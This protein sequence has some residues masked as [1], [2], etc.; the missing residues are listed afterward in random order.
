[1]P[2]YKLTE[3]FPRKRAFVTGAGSGLGRQFCLELA[4]DGWT[5]G[6]S[7]L[8]K[9]TVEETSG[10]VEEQGGR[11]LRF[12][13]DVSNRKTYQRHAGAFLKQA[14]GL[15]LLVNNAGV[16]DGGDVGDYAL[17]NW[18]WLLGINLLGVVYGCHF[19]VD[20]L[21]AERRGHIINIASA[22]AFANLPSMGAYNVSKAGVL[23]LSETLEAE[24]RPHNVG[25]SVVMPTFI[26]T[27]IMQ[28]SRGRDEEN[29][30]LARLFQKTSGLSAEDVVPL[31]LDA[32][33][34]NRLHIVFPFRARFVRWLNRFAPWL[35]RSLKQRMQKDRQGM[36][37]QMRRTEAKM[38]RKAKR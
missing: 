29:A 11:A 14:G 8:N 4:R 33:G 22:A 2:R 20:A 23:S 34:R 27:N 19:F 12:A 35:L 26:Q 10:L 5:I 15:E 37:R 1:M 7:D 31:I 38:D 16:G 28:F 18:E 17:E 30:E 24:L 32:A 13:F 21:K 3:R 25:V 36:I 6:L 9:Q